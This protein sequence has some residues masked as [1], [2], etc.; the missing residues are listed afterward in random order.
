MAAALGA[1]KGFLH[2]FSNDWAWHPDSP[3]R[4][5]TILDVLES[6]HSEG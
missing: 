2:F 1:I 5:V 3:D 6:S 4:I